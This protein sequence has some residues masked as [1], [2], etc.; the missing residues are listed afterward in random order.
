MRK[1]QLIKN[2]SGAVL[3]SCLANTRRK[4]VIRA[5]QDG[6]N[7]SGADLFG[8][9][10]S[11]ANLFGIN[12]SDTNLFAANLSRA[13]LRGTNL[14]R[15]DLRGA[16]LC[17]ADLR[18]TNLFAANLSG[19]VLRGANLYRANLNN[20]NLWDLGQDSRGYRF[21]LYFDKEAKTFTVCAGRRVFTLAKA[22]AHWRER[23]AQDPLL[24]SEIL[25]RLTMAEAIAAAVI[26]E[27]E[28]G[29]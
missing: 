22:W 12:L 17:A 26:K 11:G 6:I 15:A 9:N 25:A 27:G 18:D 14:S 1:L 2:Q 29:Q 19:A 16:E 20:A 4:A 21:F 5:I 8:I 13:D 10:L 7:L 3:Y 24:Q 28:T 23:H